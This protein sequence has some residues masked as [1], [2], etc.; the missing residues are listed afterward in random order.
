MADTAPKSY[1]STYKDI[2][3]MRKFLDSLAENLDVLGNESTSP[4]DARE[5]EV[6]VRQCAEGLTALWK[7]LDTRLSVLGTNALIEHARKRQGGGA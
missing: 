6:A 3:T 7:D 5:A 2:N 1:D 4:V